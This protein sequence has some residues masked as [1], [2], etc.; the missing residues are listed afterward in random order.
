MVKVIHF[1]GNQPPAVEIE[2]NL[3]T[4]RLNLESL[5]IR[6]A[7]MRKAG[8]NVEEEEAGLAVLTEDI[9][10]SKGEAS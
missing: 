10:L 5:K 9:A 2:T 6:I 1:G 3:R 8:L 4:I 7:N